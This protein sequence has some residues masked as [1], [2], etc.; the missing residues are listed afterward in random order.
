MSKKL[1]QTTKARITVLFIV[2]VSL[3]LLVFN[4]PALY[5]RSVDYLNDKL[6]TEFGHFVNVPYRLGLDLQGGTHLVYEA[7]TSKIESG[8]KGEAMQGVRDVIER[9]VNAFGVSEPVVQVN[10]AQDKWRIIAELAG[11]KDVNKAIE[12]IGATPLLEF[13]EQ[14]DQPPRELTVEEKQ[15]MEE[16]NERA[17]EKANKALQKALDG[18]DFEQLSKEY[19]AGM[20]AEVEGAESA[21]IT[22]NQSANLGWIDGK[23][24]HSQLFQAAEEIEPDEVYPELIES[25]SSYEILKL[26]DKRQSGQEIKASHILVCYEGASRCE[27]GYTREEAKNRIQEAKDKVTTKNFAQL[28]EEYSTGPSASQGGDLGWF[29]KEQMVKE[30]SD[31]A[32]AME[33]GEISDAV[34]TDFGFHL[35][36]RQDSR[37][38]Y[39]YEVAH[40]SINKKTETDILPPQ[41]EWVL[42]DLSGKQL[43][44]SRVEFEQTTQAPLVALEFNSKGKDLFAEIT[45][46]NIGKPVAIFLD[47]QPISIPRVNEEITGGSA[48]IQGDFTLEEAQL[49]AQRLN[50]GALPVPIELVGQQ[51]I[52]A[53]LG[54]NS[55]QKSLFAGIVGLILVGAFMILYYRLPGLLAVLAL[56]VYGVVVLFIFK[57]IPVTLTLSG[58]AGFILSV[59]MAVDANVLIFERLKEELKVGKPLGTA[60][61]EGFKRAWTSIRDGNVSTLITCF[62][63]AWFGTSM[64]KGFAITLGIGV[65]VSMFSALVVTRQFLTLLVKPGSKKKRP[66][67]L[68]GVKKQD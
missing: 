11:V 60:I 33:N 2:L 44:S 7:D 20:E 47:G 46:R 25:E 6:G 52:G 48:V 36:F 57:S 18:Q 53:S 34:E 61:E 21:G 15:E 1:K 17:K 37:G 62:I 59:G 41:E 19:S 28:A 49:L 67:W 66:L 45:K 13:K 42:T 29:D 56:G 39:E 63:L 64:I 4:A 27:E 30:F 14:N 16:Y 10:K 51:T 50:A 23:G 68:F 3:L 58:I 5:D 35:I 32:F 22:I 8:E 54:Q 12:M 31:T 40:I 9:R 38:K 26:K 55:L 24:A 65:L 43:E